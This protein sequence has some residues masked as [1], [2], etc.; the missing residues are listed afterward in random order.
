MIACDICHDRYH[1]ECIEPPLS[2]APR[3]RWSCAKCKDK[4]RNVTKGNS[5]SCAHFTDVSFVFLISRTNP[6]KSLHL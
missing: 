4:R 3:G 5:I 6:T 1:L 2:R